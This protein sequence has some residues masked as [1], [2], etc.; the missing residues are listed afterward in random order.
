ML[1]LTYETFKKEWL[2][3]VQAGQPA[4]FELGRRFSWKIISQ[5]FELDDNTI[6]QGDAVICDGSGDG[7][8][9][10]AVLLRSEE[11]EDTAA[12]DTWYLIQSKYGTA[13]SGAHT[14]LLESQKVMD[15]L[16]GRR[17][18]L[19]SLASGLVERLQQFRANASDRDRLVLVFATSEPMTPEELQI[20]DAIRQ[21]GQHNLGDIFEVEDV[22]LQKLFNRMN[23]NVNA[24][25]RI[26]LE[27]S[28]VPSGHELLVGSVGL[29]QLYDFLKRYKLQKGDLDILYEKNV[30][31]FLGGKRKVNKGIEDTLVKNPERFG[32]YNNGIT[33][34]VHNFELQEGNSYLLTEPYV[35]NGCQ[36]TRTIWETLLKK[37]DAG[38]TGQNPQIDS[39]KKQLEQG[40]VVI[41][42]VKVG[43]HGE[44]LLKKTTK[45]TNSQN[46]V[47]EKD[48][49]ALESKF[50][51]WA[52]GIANQYNIFLEI[53]R[54][55]WDSQR[56]YQKQH[57]NSKQF[58]ESVNAF[59][60]LKVYGSAWLGEIAAAFGKNPPFAPGGDIFHKI[61]DQVDFDESDLYAAYLLLGAS[62]TLRFGRSAPSTSRRQTRYLFYFIV[63]E[64]LKDIFNQG[65]IHY[66]NKQLTNAFT[67]LLHPDNHEVGMEI[68]ELAANAV[69][70]YMNSN[71]ENTIMKED[72]LIAKGYD[73]NSFLKWEGFAKLESTPNLFITIGNYKRD[74]KRGMKGDAP[75]K[76]K[77]LALLR[78]G[79]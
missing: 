9:D 78:K 2:E 66:S 22:S 56:A 19:S 65:E 62:S 61:T 3:E 31:K 34:V 40:I 71:S 33:I 73:I 38:G 69:D 21:L 57:P 51:K 45:Y 70:E 6:E 60:L 36:T 77:V 4:T 13:F 44:E 10:L 24:G 64:L 35:V 47:S 48:F 67:V 43:E 76:D 59:D 20:M 53:Q 72:G 28:L 39:W 54:G 75:L 68:L 30:R 23:D 15:T 79:A 58:K 11:T 55:G 27:A 1:N 7:G 63:S 42:V 49:M 14:L 16:A 37:L 5:W 52:K 8:I 25:S 18:N 29:L 74:L 46:A 17:T 41:K 50:Q 26:A 32:L 12:G